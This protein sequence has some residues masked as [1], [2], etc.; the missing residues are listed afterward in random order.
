MYLASYGKCGSNLLAPY[1]KSVHVFI[2]VYPGQLTKM[3]VRWLTPLFPRVVNCEHTQYQWS[4]VTVDA[5]WCLSP[6]VTGRLSWPLWVNCGLSALTSYPC[7]GEPHP[8]SLPFPPAQQAQLI[9]ER[10]NSS[11]SLMNTV[12][13][14]SLSTF[15][16][17]QD[18][19]LGS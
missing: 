9:I 4:V 1:V 19:L 7:S 2:C 12:F 17:L 13:C 3:P 8:L 10:L 6:S 5:E 15:K 11:P 18:S 16:H 14:I